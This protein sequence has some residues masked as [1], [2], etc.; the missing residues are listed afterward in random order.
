MDTREFLSE[1]ARWIQEVR[2]SAVA[3][4]EERL[5]RANLRWL[6]RNN[7]AWSTLD[8]ALANRV[9]EVIRSLKTRGPNANEPRE[10]DGDRVWSVFAK[11]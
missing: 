10:R 1:R 7:Y 11:M 2:L 6:K 8:E 3:R 9:L 5:H 4:D